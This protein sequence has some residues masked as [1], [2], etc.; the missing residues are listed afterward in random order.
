MKSKKTSNPF[1]L[2]IEPI[3][4]PKFR[5][6]PTLLQIIAERKNRK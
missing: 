3:N 4:I 6:N 2:K 5:I 1:N